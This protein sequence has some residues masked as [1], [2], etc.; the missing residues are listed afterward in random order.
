MNLIKNK[1]IM[2][3]LS[4]LASFL[5]IF[6]ACNNE[7]EYDDSVSYQT[8]YVDWNEKTPDTPQPPVSDTNKKQ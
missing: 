1:K 6:N 4:I 2:L 5:L 7:N 8:T 3:C